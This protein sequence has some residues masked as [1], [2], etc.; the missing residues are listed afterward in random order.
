MS[1]PTEQ[2]LTSLRERVSQLESEASRIGAIARV[3]TVILKLADD[4]YDAVLES[5]VEALEELGLQTTVQPAASAGAI[6]R[7]SIALGKFQGVMQATTPIGCRITIMRL[8]LL[9]L[10]MTS[11]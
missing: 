1:E 8:S 9:G 11:P 10:G 2:D 6:F 3:R 5:V 7:V 4:D